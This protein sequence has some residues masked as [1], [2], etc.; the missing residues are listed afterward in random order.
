MGVYGTDA[1]ENQIQS[2]HVHGRYAAS[3]P[4]CPVPS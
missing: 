2:I 1:E 4:F 3:T